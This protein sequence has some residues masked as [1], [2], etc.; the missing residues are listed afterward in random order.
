MKE[1]LIMSL[2]EEDRNCGCHD[3]H[4]RH[5]PKHSKHDHCEGCACDQLR[6]LDPGRLVFVTL[7]GSAVRLGPLT[8]A[9]FD[10]KHCCA[11]FIDNSGVTPTGSVLILDCRDIVAVTLAP[12]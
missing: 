12:V 5:D 9:C 1:E 6:D 8:F 7:R 10:N 2:F 4:D 3:K 11:T